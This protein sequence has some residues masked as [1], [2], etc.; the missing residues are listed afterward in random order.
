MNDD[1]GKIVLTVN[2]RRAVPEFERLKFGLG[3]FLVVTAQSGWGKTTLAR[4][5]AREFGVPIISQWTTAGTRQTLS[6]VLHQLRHESEGYPYA[7]SLYALFLDVCHE[8]RRRQVPFILI[9]E[10]DRLAAGRRFETWN[11]LRDVLDSTGTNAGLF[12]TEVTRRLLAAP[13]PYL[14]QVASRI[15]STV[16]FARPG[17]S[18]ARKI[19]ESLGL[20]LADD[21]LKLLPA[22]SR[23]SLRP[24]VDRFREIEAAAREAGAVGTLVIKE[25]ARLGIFSSP[26]QSSDTDAGPDD[27]RQAH[28]VQ[29]LRA[30]VA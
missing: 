9:D 28:T 14:S 5:L 16:T 12:G 23:A 2:I 30:G 15:I 29:G 27:A 4:Y 3:R 24:L 17:L 10:S 20:R 22:Q 8:L 21:A 25:C 6:S 26:P 18:D 19:A 11:A 1:Y 13:G 7:G